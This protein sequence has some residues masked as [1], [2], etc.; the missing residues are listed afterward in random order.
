MELISANNSAINDNG[1]CYSRVET[2]IK[3][4]PCASSLQALSSLCLVGRV[5]AP[6]IVNEATVLEMVAKTWK[7]KVNVASMYEST[8]NQN[9]FE[10]GFARPEDR[11]WA[12][13][14]GPWRV[15]GYSLILRA[16]SPRNDFSDILDSM[17]I[18]IQIHNLPRDYF[19]VNNG[20]ILGG[21]A[22]KVIKVE[23]DEGKPALWKKFLRVLIKMDVN[24][25]LFSGCYFELE[26]GGHRWIQFKYERVGIF[27]YNCG[28]LGHQRRGC[29]LSSPVTVANDLGVPFPMFGPWLSTESTYLDVFAGANSF[30]PSLSASSRPGRDGKRTVALTTSMDELGRNSV[31]LNRMVRES[32]RPVIATGRRFARGK[33]ANQ[34]AWVPKHNTVPSTT[35][36]AKLGNK[37]GF[38]EDEKVKGTLNFPKVGLNHVDYPLVLDKEVG[39]GLGLQE[40][41]IGP[42]FSSTGPV[43]LQP[44]N[45][46]R[47]NINSGPC[48]RN[49]PFEHHVTPPLAREPSSLS[50]KKLGEKVL[51]QAVETLQVSGPVAKD[52][53]LM[54]INTHNGNLGVGPSKTISN[55]SSICG[56]EANVDHDESLAL[57]NFFQAQDTLLQ[58]LKNFGNLDLYEIKA[59]GGDIGV[60][61]SSEVNDR[62][63]LFKKRKFDGASASLC[64][65]PWK[66]LRPHPWAIRDFPWDTEDQANANYTV[67]DEPSEDISL[68]NSDF[69]SDMWKTKGKNILIPKCPTLENR[70]I[71]TNTTDP[72]GQNISF[73]RRC[74]FPLTLQLM[75]SG[76]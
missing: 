23:L 61:P 40:D 73:H 8:N 47:T 70:F 55:E 54:S 30:S 27:C 57:S 72:Y 39:D 21:K 41:V 22:G 46:R 36:L 45:T 14:N 59:I 26:K 20:N 50:K 75:K 3:L 48:E 66:L 12:L 33:L 42:A 62:T 28:M 32:K 52:I 15:R 9:C 63:T 25:P 31:R 17:I 38:G 29:S 19:S 64:S 51:S 68:S 16:W 53:N 4:T 24:H 60:P 56:Q 35:G 71:S 76:R 49:G 43:S 44:I 67:E 13:D 11:A 6:M 69:G 18:W 10:L 58:E 7:F 5:I 34:M 74:R 65:R 1:K 37:G 2:T